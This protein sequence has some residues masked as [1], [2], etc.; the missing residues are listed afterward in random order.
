MQWDMWDEEVGRGTGAERC[1][2][3][4]TARKDRD[5]ETRDSRA[6]RDEGQAGGRETET[7][8]QTGRAGDSTRGETVKISEQT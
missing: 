2:S 6:R 4:E 7:D 3:I 5:R 1:R 8:P